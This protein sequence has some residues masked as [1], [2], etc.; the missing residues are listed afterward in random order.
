VFTCL[1]HNR[2]VANIVA[3]F[4]LSPKDYFLDKVEPLAAGR[5]GIPGFLRG[6][7]GQLGDVVGPVPAIRMLPDELYGDGTLHA[8]LIES[9]QI[10][11]IF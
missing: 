8:Y 1:S 11:H 9:F 6:R 7:V 3:S 5:D 10:F 4:L 2:N